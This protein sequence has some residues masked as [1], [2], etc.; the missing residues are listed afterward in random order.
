LLQEAFEIQSSYST[1]CA[2]ANYPRLAFTRPETRQAISWLQSVEKLTVT[3]GID[4][5][6]LNTL[7]ISF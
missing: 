5:A 3:G 7:Q 2:E 6:T 1:T 4:E